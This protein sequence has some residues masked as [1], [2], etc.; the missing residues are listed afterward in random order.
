MKFRC[1]NCNHKLSVP[2]KHAGRKAT[3]PHC[4]QAL[5]IPGPVIK[6]KNIP[7]RPRTSLD[8]FR[9]LEMPPADVPEATA[10]SR[11]TDRSHAAGDG[12][13]KPSPNDLRLLEVPPA[14]L[15]ETPAP[16]R[17]PDRSQATGDNGPKPSPTDL[18]LLEVPPADVSEKPD[19]DRSDEA[20]EQLQGLQGGLINKDREGP[21]QR[22]LPWIVDIFLYPMNKAA[23][24]M[25]LIC[26]GIP[27]FLRL[28]V[29]FCFGL[30]VHVQVLLILWAI[31]IVVHWAVLSLLVLYM[32]W[33]VW[34]CIRE[35]AAGS[36]R[37]AET[38]GA[39][40]GF[41]EIFARAFRGAVALGLCMAPAVFYVASVQ[42][43]DPVFWAL[44]AF[45]G[46]AFPMALLAL[47][48][49]D[50]F[51]GLN[52][53]LIV[54]S[55]LKTFFRYLPLVPLCYLLCLLFPVAYA[56]I[57]NQRYWHLA[58]PLLFLAYYLILVM[59]H[60]LGRFYFKNEERLYWDA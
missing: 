25:L 50:S 5:V 27:F 35:S 58:Y 19:A 36:I 38:V 28:V 23:L 56:L 24:T 55:I 21:P 7:P 15:P 29:K 12:K 32:N 41:G 13:P 6:P 52:P 8:D 1:D 37:A 60:L 46:L 49:H 34:E 43:I 3:C 54:S 2:D 26:T 59:G 17:D 53:F 14:D 40:P 39:T 10:R 47:V 30:M 51:S 22:K 42:A 31:S 4:G 33:Y 45:G 9:F 18:R 57:P 48:V 20:Y 16:S 44:Y 11:G